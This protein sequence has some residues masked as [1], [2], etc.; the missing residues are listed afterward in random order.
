MARRP[1]QRGIYE[2]SQWERYKDISPLVGNQLHMSNVDKMGARSGT[3][4]VLTQG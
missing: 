3:Y 1:G 4:C 2:D